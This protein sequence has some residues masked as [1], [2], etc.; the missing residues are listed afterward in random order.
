MIS[1]EGYCFGELSRFSLRRERIGEMS[2]PD[3]LAY[4]LMFVAVPIA[5]LLPGP[6]GLAVALVCAIIGAA[7]LYSAHSRGIEEPAES[8]TLSLPHQTVFPAAPD[9]ITKSPEL[10][11]L[12]NQLA[13]LRETDPLVYVDTCYK[14]VNLT[15]V[16]PFILHNRGKTVAHRIQINPIELGV[17]KARFKEVDSLDA[18]SLTEVLPE[19]E[20]A[21]PIFRHNLVNFLHHEANRVEQGS[22]REFPVPMTIK[23]ED[24]T[25]DRHFETTFVLAYS[26]YNKMM[27][28]SHPSLGELRTICEVKRTK[29]QVI[30]DQVAS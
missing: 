10:T 22:V 30:S 8:E 16:T 13:K 2:K 15:N 12:V 4:G 17:G 19:V 7:L 20:S 24:V 25:G 9:S 23:Y 28:D 1:R 14:R 18:G 21:G 29:I 26:P 11:Q 5:Y 27:V 3:R 6:W